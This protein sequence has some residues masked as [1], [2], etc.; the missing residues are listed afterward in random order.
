MKNIA[1]LSGGYDA[2]RV[3]SLKSAAVVQANLDA[4][5]YKTYIIDVQE[6]E[7][8]EIV[9]GQAMDKNDFTLSIEGLK[10][11]FD[12]VFMCLHGSPAEDGRIQGYLEMM[13]M[14][15]TGCGIK[16]SANTMD[17]AYSKMIA[18]KFEG[19]NTAAF[20][21]LSNQQMPSEAVLST[22]NF[23]IFIKPNAAGSSFG[24][25]KVHQLSEVHDA[26]LEAYRHSSSILIEEFIEGRELAHGIIEMHGTKIALPITEIISEND[27]FDYEA[28]YEGKSKE[29]TPAQDIPA[30]IEKNIQ[31]ISLKLFDAFGCKGLTRFDYFLKDDTVYFLEANTLPGLSEASIFPQ[32]LREKGIS[33]SQAFESLLEEVMH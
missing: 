26:V 31:D 7:W 9:S 25:S 27:F 20:V 18:S 15:Y 17:K 5:K 10:I 33:L 32:Q 8:I 6:K 23:P 1:I 19:V 28:K 12:A 24:V 14:P 16:C 22:F 4:K 11:N 30:Q 3:V 21:L 13:K 29:I 2:E